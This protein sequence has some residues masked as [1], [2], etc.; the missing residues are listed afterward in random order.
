M[1]ACVMLIVHVVPIVCVASMM[2]EVLIV[3]SSVDYLSGADI[4]WS[5][6]CLCICVA[7]II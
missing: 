6:D 4:I 5:A 3:I 2:W 7:L 1:C